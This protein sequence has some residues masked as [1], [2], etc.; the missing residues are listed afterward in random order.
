MAYQNTR[1]KLRACVFGICNTLYMRKLL[2]NTEIENY[3][4][5]P[6][7]NISKMTTRQFYGIMYFDKY[8]GT[9]KS[10]QRG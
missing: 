4:K 6:I 10:V 1:S 9:F 2:H 5:I 7:S 3:L 8:T